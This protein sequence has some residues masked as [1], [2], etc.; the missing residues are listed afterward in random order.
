MAEF[1]QSEEPT[2]RLTI[3]GWPRR[4]QALG[5]F[6]PDGF[7]GSLA[8]EDPQHRLNVLQ[9]TGQ[10]LNLHGHPG[11][12]IDIFERHDL[13]CAQYGTALQR[14]A[15]L[16]HHGKSLRQ[17]GRFRLADEKNRMALSLLENDAAGEDDDSARSL[18][19]LRAVTMTWHAMAL[20]H[21]G[22]DAESEQ[23]FAEALAIFT[24]Q[25]EATHR[26][27]VAVFL[28]QRALW[29]GDAAEAARQATVAWDLSGP[30][31]GDPTQTDQW[32][33][34][35]VAAS[36]ARNRGEA[37]VL[38]GRID[39]GS[40]WLSRAQAMAEETVFVEEMIPGLRA[41][42]MAARNRSDYR[43]ARELLERVWPLTAAGPYPMY[44]AEARVESAALLDAVGDERAAASERA[45]AHAL[46]E[47]DGPPFSFKLRGS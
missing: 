39:E 47:A 31:E 13:E 24:A 36:A 10:A 17:A 9:W 12:A 21:R 29:R 3:E 27:V 2:T 37:L 19:L 5:Q 44:E 14:A 45:Q 15:G 40:E 22:A 38:L 16:A 43:L 8:I 34:R 23:C 42:A 6:F 20:A 26:S 46:A 35:K 41:Q 18:L 33:V 4:L 28:A 11:R 32:S 25:F 7:D 1:V 30:R